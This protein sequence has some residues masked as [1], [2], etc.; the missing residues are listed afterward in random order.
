MLDK[1][2][3]AKSAAFVMSFMLLASCSENSGTTQATTGSS[4]TS[5]ENA[6]A[7][8]VAQS[9]LTLLRLA[10]VDT[11]NSRGIFTLGWRQMFNPQS[12]SESTLGQAMAIGF[13]GSSTAGTSFRRG[14]VDMG[15]VYVN[16][17]SNHLALLQHTGLDGGIIYTSSFGL[18][19]GGTNIEFVS[20]GSYQFEV[21]G[22]NKF[23]A[24][25]ARDG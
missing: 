19:E 1:M 8:S 25:T 11:T 21:S 18:R 7:A 23:S 24:F 14:G 10:G 16:Y 20:S 5:S 2:S 4:S 6:L 12:Q 15:S 9:E 22:S 13:D 17:S 3:L